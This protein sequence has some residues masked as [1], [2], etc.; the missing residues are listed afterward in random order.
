MTAVA[1]PAWQG[2]GAPLVIVVL[3]LLVEAALGG[4]APFA[5]LL[6]LPANA[7]GGLAGWFDE[8]LN[9]QHRSPASRAMRGT[10][11]TVLVL[12][13]AAA[14]GGF[15]ASVA[16]ASPDGWTIDFAVLFFFVAPGR[17][18][19]LL[20]RVS[21]GLRGDAPDR[22]R[23]AL[24]PLVFHDVAALDVH[25][26]ARGAIEAGAIR[27]NST[28]VAPVAWYLLAGL[29]GLVLYRTVDLFARRLGYPAPSSLA[30]AGVAARIA[31]L[32]SL[33][34]A[35]LAGVILAMAAVFVPGARPGA[36]LAAMSSVAGSA[37]TL[38]HGP[39]LAATAGALG[40]LLGGP[41]R[42][43]GT[44]VPLAWIGG[45]GRARAGV[46]DLVRAIYLL[47]IT[48]VLAIGLTVALAF[49]TV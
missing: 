17:T 29:P 22:A 45:D 3:A 14:L 48:A 40:L 30:F 4:I 44:S 24:V 26:I 11:V 18:W 12:V 28:L 21:R 15:L 20:R 7:I 46:Q 47:A 27:F 6:E 31:W 41:R 25:A 49:A 34:P 9:R 8:R 19:A 5:R 37:A 13:A 42:I 2:F 16:A 33:V 32:S 38:G 39:A 36:A 43:A 35:L 1:L 10:I 23:A